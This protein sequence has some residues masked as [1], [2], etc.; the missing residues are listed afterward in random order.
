MYSLGFLLAYSV[1]PAFPCICP[2]VFSASPPKVAQN[3]RGWAN[4]NKNYTRFKN[5]SSEHNKKSAVAPFLGYYVPN[6]MSGMHW[7]FATIRLGWGGQ[8]G[9]TKFAQMNRA[10]PFL[11]PTLRRG[12]PNQSTIFCNPGAEAAKDVRNFIDSDDVAVL[13]ER[14]T[15]KFVDTLIDSNS[16]G[17]L[18]LSQLSFYVGLAF[19]VFS[20]RMFVF[21]C[22]CVCDCC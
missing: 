15:V 1:F 6:G 17:N 10:T 16:Y 18:F 5:Y 8:N 7:T 22:I 4:K 19:V 11:R 14:R 2:I 21:V 3:F 12:P 20:E 13:V 9:A